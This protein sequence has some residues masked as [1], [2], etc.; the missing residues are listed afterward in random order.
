MPQPN[1]HFPFKYQNRSRILYGRGQ[2]TN[3]QQFTDLSLTQDT[4]S[5]IG[6]DQFGKGYVLAASYERVVLGKFDDNHFR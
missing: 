1:F 2:D 6:I 4:D 3:G 5:E